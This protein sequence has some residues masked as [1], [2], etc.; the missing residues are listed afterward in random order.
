MYKKSNMCILILDNSTPIFLTSGNTYANE[1]IW[2]LVYARKENCDKAKKHC[3][4]YLRILK[5]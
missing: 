4:I 3:F 2:Y 1:K 5:K